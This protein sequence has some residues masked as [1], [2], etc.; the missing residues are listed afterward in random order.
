MIYSV[1]VSRV[2]LCLEGE[3]ACPQPSSI[4]LE[5]T[6]Q[7]L[8]L[9]QFVLWTPYIWNEHAESSVPTH[10]YTYSK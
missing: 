10:K 8:N 2:K 4:F 1:R 5:T 6:L 3:D 9:P 7:K